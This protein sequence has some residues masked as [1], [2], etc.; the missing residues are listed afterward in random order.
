MGVNS[1]QMACLSSP[2][3][4]QLEA[5]SN[6]AACKYT[7]RELT[8]QTRSRQAKQSKAKQSTAQ[9]TMAIMAMQE[10]QEA[11]PADQINYLHGKRTTKAKK[12]LLQKQAHAAQA[13]PSL[14]HASWMMFM[15]QVDLGC[16]VSARS[17]PADK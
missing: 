2:A 5:P 1:N 6:I 7:E 10:Y 4:Q 8:C 9:R 17:L 14:A 11:S 15:V 12:H 13:S 3:L 16:S